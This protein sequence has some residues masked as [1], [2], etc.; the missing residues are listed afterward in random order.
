MLRFEDNQPFS[1]GACRFE[2]KPAHE[3]ETNPRILIPIEISGLP[4]RAVLDTGGLYF[5]CSA[6]FAREMNIDLSG[7]LGKEQIRIRHGLLNGEL[8]RIRITFLAEES[9]GN[10]LELEVTAFIYEEELNYPL[11]LGW[12][13]CME[14]LQFAIQPF[15]EACGDSG[16]IF[17]FGS[18]DEPLADLV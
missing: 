11:F 13:G 8:Y 6:S 12:Y 1:T 4:T 10:S 15:T 9:H 5:I 16:G 14:R 17:Y 7:G 2:Y 3:C 18:S